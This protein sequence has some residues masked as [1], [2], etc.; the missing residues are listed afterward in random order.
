MD[1]DILLDKLHVTLLFFITEKLILL[2]DGNRIERVGSCTRAS[3]S[4][5]AMHWDGLR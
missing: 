1:E 4:I 5:I 3:V 2:A